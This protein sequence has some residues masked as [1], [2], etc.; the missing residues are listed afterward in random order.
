M[1]PCIQTMHVLPLHPLL[2]AVHYLDTKP[3]ACRELPE[4]RRAERS[5][6]L[7]LKT[8]AW[9]GERLATCFRPRDLP[10]PPSNSSW[11]TLRFGM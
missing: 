6:L 2:V 4:S 1:M 8:C 5:R 11:L 3:N 7:F 9:S 10:C